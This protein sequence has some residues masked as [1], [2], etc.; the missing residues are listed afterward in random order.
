MSKATATEHQLWL[1]MEDDDPVS[2][3]AAAGLVIPEASIRRIKFSVTSSDEIL[4]AQPVEN[5]FP[6]THW[7]Q[8]QDNPSLGLPLQVGT[9]ES[10]GATDPGKCDGHFGFIELPV[11]IYHP[12]HVTE[13]GKILNMVCLSCLR[14]KD[15]KAKG[16]GSGKQNKF[17]ACSYCQDL[18]P[19]CVTEVKKSNGADTLQ[20][21]APLHQDVADGIWSF[22]DQFGLRTGRTTHC[23]PLLPME[24]Q[25]IM[26]RISEETRSRLAAR[27]YNLQD[28]FVLNYVCVPPN[29]LN[30]TNVP[31]GNTYMCSSDNSNK[32][33]RKVLNTIEKIKVSGISHSNFEAREVGADDLQVAVADYIAMKGMAKGSQ[34]V[35][36]TRQP[37][38]K[39]WQQKIKT[40]FISKS[41]SF[42]CR[43]VIT[44]DPYIGLDIVGVPN[45]IARRMSVEEYVTDYNIA[46]LQDMVDKGLCLTY[47]DVDSSTYSL[48]DQNTNKKRTILK[49]GQNVDRRVLDGDVVFLN[50]PP[51]TDMHSVQAFYIHVHNDH[52]IKINPLICGPLGADF[53]GDCVHIFYPRSVSARVEAKEL[54]TV[55]KQLVCSHNAKLNFQLKNDCLL[56]MKVMCDRKYSQKEA[57]QIAMFS[58]GIIPPSYPY[59][60]IPQILQAIDALPPLPSHPNK[61]TVGTLVSTTI[62]S[63]LSEKGPREATKLLNLLQPLLMES[64]LMDGFSVNLRDFN[65]PNQMLKTNKNISHELDKF[66][67]PIVD[68]ISHCSALGLLVDLKS[69]AT[70]TK[71]VEQLGFL[72]YQLQYSGRLYSCS[73]VD[74]C[75]KFL[76]KSC[77]SNKVE[78]NG[79]VKSSF[80]DGLNPYEEL[81]HSISA[82][83]KMLRS[84]GLAEPGNLFKNM[85]AILR[86]V[87]VCYDGTIRTSCSK[88]IVQ[89]NSM[90]VS[91]S[92]TPGDPVGIL[93]ATAVANAA[94]KAVLDPNQNNMTSW[95][96]MKEILLTNV[97]SKSDI[98]CKRAILYLNKCSCGH[99]FCMERAALKVQSSLKAIKVEDCVVEVSIRYQQET[100]EASHCLVGHIHF[101]KEQLNQMEITLGSI[102][103]TCQEV[104]IKKRRKMGKSME[105]ANII[106]SECL[107]DQVSCLQLF[108]D[109]SSTTGLSES[110]IFHLMI[111]IIFPILLETIIKGDPRVQKAK[112]IWVEPELPCWVKSS[113][114]EQKGELALE[115]T[116]EKTAVAENAESWGIA[117][118]AC[119][120]VMD[121]IDITRSMPYSIQEVQQ[122][123]GISYAFDRVTQHLSKAVTMV[124][125]SVLK[126]HLT[127]IAS[128]MTC[129]GNLH[130]FNSSGYKA[131]CQSMKAQAPF[132]EATLSKPT[133]S[134]QKS[135]EKVY[136]DQLDSV[137][138]TCSWGGHVAIGTGSAFE[139]HWNNETH[140]SSNEI[141]GCGLY[142]FLTMVETV[143]TAEDKMLAPRS[144]CLYD[145]DY[146]PGDEVEED[147]VVHLGTNNLISWTDKPKDNS[148]QCD[149][150]CRA[151]THSIAQ[152]DQ[153]RQNK[154]NWNWKND[155]PSWCKGNAGGHPD[156]SFAGSIATSG[157]KRRFN[158]QVFERKQRKHHWSSTAARQ[159]DKTNGFRANV[160]GTQNFSIAEP[161]GSGRWNRKTS[162]F[163]QGSSKAEWKTEVS[164]CRGSNTR[165]WRAQK[166]SSARQGGSSSFTP[167]EQHI[168]TQVEPIMNNVKRIIRESRDGIKLSS[169]DEAFVVRN[170]LMYH[171][172]K[173]KKMAG[174]DNYIMVARHQKFLSSRCFYVASS[175]GS[176]SDFSY[177][178]CLE[179]F[180][181]IHY[182]D[183]ADSFCRKYFK[184]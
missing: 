20:L 151:A 35:T 83:E 30:T 71:V 65:E 27:G 32:L 82:R 29:C 179:N 89:F 67:E 126:E 152:E 3:A 17:T 184:R 158:G 28:G 62:L 40:L 123:F 181:R 116:V 167:M 42:S 1:K 57:N 146:L 50:R 13:L 31:D 118:D 127:L 15:G 137:V 72:G 140:S 157:W 18:P 156:S 43:A 49:V 136:S 76:N 142:D 84:K 161:S 104:I 139:I 2:A 145:V 6:I 175:N 98:N 180:I 131:T 41:S 162:T 51:S 113:S 122:V 56:A 176:C 117:I 134:F 91:R 70:L 109:A 129:T 45:E 86:D 103:E 141:R 171:P 47:R 148:L 26:Q 37:Q 53:D 149:F 174:Q 130:G 168:Y 10:C 169:E 60:T 7:S 90:Y 14:L 95:D 154:S 24:V 128:R 75:K 66:R 94:Y 77:G 108:L 79:V 133:Q 36:F 120:P 12:S 52:T 16:K 25:N 138:S 124:T 22:L 48:D 100:T 114:V 150:D 85:M 69:D 8:L 153:G 183:A 121:L 132:M 166:N 5:S 96:L 97:G 11:P 159:D 54:F 119:L 165:N 102:I 135:A 81:L 170:I 88:S 80:H 92:V 46:R 101:Q 110:N 164:Q 61:E 106:L 178:K 39:Q 105:R 23:R 93:A 21:R 64:L 74:D 4:K 44:G 19:L 112:I 68:V 107:C 38:P 125:K 78:A 73:L 172:E 111:N 147:E 173:E 144:S 59:W 58:S 87:I 163:G 63:T 99:K 55:E 34:H 177:K 160:S 182:P 33:L 115:V 155:K 9:C 143:G